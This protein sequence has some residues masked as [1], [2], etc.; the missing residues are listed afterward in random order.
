[1][2]VAQDHVVY[3]SFYRLERPVGRVAVSPVMEGILRDGRMA[4]AYVQNDLGGAWARDDFGNYAFSCQ[5]GGERQR[6]MAVRLG[7]NLVMYALCLDYKA[8]QV[9]VEY[10]MR[11]RRFRP[12]DGAED[13]RGTK[14]RCPRADRGLHRRAAD[15][16]R[17]ARRCGRVRRHVHGLVCRV[18][19]ARTCLRS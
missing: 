1:E 6:E 4:V 12:E 2:L 3:R 15:R 19:R 10:L 18:C 8:D 17:R 11:K 7:I 9:H 14:S 16:A 5:P 13:A